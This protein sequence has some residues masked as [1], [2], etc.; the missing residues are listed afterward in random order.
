MVEVFHLRTTAS[1][2]E[3]SKCCSVGIMTF[4]NLVSSA[5]QL[6][7][8]MVTKVHVSKESKEERIGNLA[9]KKGTSTTATTTATIPQAKTSDARP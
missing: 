5:V 3:R 4:S 1:I 8:V 2:W 6:L 7:V 9:F